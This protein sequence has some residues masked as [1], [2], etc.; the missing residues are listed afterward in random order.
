[1]DIADSKPPNV[2]PK[3]DGRA[4]L[5]GQLGNSMTGCQTFS[6]LDPFTVGSVHQLVGC[7][8]VKQSVVTDA[9]MLT[10]EVFS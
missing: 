3:I 10:F 9:L 5:E 1:M 8:G 7:R 6:M 4:G 2:P